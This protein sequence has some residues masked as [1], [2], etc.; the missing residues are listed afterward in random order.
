[1]LKR[2][3]HT[4]KR[5]LSELELSELEELS[6]SSPEPEPLAVLLSSSLLFFF[7]FCFAAA[8]CRRVPMMYEVVTADVNADVVA[9]YWV[10]CALR[11]LECISG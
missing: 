3:S 4:K 2:M 10:V 1:M 11:L 9:A 7:G 8:A 6:V 5:P